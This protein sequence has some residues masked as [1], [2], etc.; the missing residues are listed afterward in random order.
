MFLILGPPWA[1][2][3]FKRGPYWYHPQV[4][5]EVWL[6]DEIGLFNLAGISQTPGQSIQQRMVGIF[7]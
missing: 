6:M 1:R 2:N 7:F 5:G 3:D 4:P